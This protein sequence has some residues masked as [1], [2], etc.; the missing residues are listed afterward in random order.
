MNISVIQ[1]FV[2]KVKLLGPLQQT[3]GEIKFFASLWRSLLS[4]SIVRKGLSGSK[5][6]LSD[7]LTETKV[8][9]LFL[10]T[11]NLGPSRQI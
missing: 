7:Y 9:V 8:M 2:L 1:N 5:Y 4:C 11:Q 10:K 6:V 3:K